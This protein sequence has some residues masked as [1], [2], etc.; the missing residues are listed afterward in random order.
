MNVFILDFRIYLTFSK[1]NKKDVKSFHLDREYLK[2]FGIDTLIDAY[3]YLYII[4]SKN[5]RIVI[6]N[7]QFLNCA[8]L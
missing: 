5:Q 1:H 4:I 8:Y 2:L 6:P 7:F 3:R